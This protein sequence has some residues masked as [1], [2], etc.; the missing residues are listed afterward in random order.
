MKK[1][2]IYIV[3]V[4]I[5]L[6]VSGCAGP[7]MGSSVY[8]NEQLNQPMKVYQGTVLSVTD[9]QIKNQNQPSGIGTV[10]GGVAGAIVGS[11]IGHGPDRDVTTLLGGLVGAGL[12]TAAE[13]SGAIIPGLEVEVKLDE[14]RKVLIVQRKDHIFTVGEKV[15]VLEDSDGHMSV[16]S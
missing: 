3:L 7:Y 12:G 10:A 9:V 5:C 8:S 16:R 6:M 1:Q 15:R 2:G 13:Q 14:G 4:A 11:A